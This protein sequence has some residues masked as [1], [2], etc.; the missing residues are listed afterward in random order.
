MSTTPIPAGINLTVLVGR[1]SRP[2]ELRV[3]PSGDSVLTLE[4]TVRVDGAPTES[5]PVAWFDAP[6]QAAAGRS[7][8]SCW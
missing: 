6:P 1:L 7:A 2:P 4:V 5:V 8:R 3:L